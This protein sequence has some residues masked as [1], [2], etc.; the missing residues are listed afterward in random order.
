[1]A[2]TICCGRPR[3]GKYDR[4][5]NVT[6]DAETVVNEPKG[7][8]LPTTWSKFVIFELAVGLEGFWN[9]LDLS[10]LPFLHN[11]QAQTGAAS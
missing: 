10:I 8:F 2:R 7:G 3:N 5:C 6:R 9:V 11:P 1:M 4:G